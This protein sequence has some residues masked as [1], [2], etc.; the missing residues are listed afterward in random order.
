MD[1]N[2]KSLLKRL[3]FQQGHTR[4]SPS[5]YF[6]LHLPWLESSMVEDELTEHFSYFAQRIVE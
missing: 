2:P 1:F 5:F 4:N 3:Y 6:F